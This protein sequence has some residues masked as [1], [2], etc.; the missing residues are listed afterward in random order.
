MIADIQWLE[1]KDDAITFPGMMRFGS[2]VWLPEKTPDD[3]VGEI[4]GEPRIWTDG[5][6]PMVPDGS[7]FDGS[8]EMFQTGNNFDASPP[9]ELNSVGIPKDCRPGRGAYEDGYAQDWDA[10]TP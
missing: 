4:L 5:S 9:L 10:V 2:L 3:G 6:Y 1:A 8:P 7:H